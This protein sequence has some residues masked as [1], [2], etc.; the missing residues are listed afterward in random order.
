M[1]NKILIVVD[2]QY[3]F[4]SPEGALYVPG[5]E[6]IVDSIQEKINDTS[7]KDIIYTLDTHDNEEYISSEESKLF[8]IH[9]E[10]NS[11]GWDLFKIQ[12]RNRETKLILEEGIF[13]SA[14]D[15]SVKNEFVF[16]KDKFSIWE[17]NSNY[18]K[19][20]IE[21]Y[22]KDTEIVIVGVATNYCVFWN[23]MGYRERGYKNVKIMSD[24]VKGIYDDTYEKNIE[25]MKNKNI[26]FEG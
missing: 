5:A 16:M 11:F 23:A 22:D 10:F 14:K 9:C 7:F 12:T 20:F 18:E 3:D 6:T 8:P 15:F 21:R 26:K 17:G 24:S 2:Y 25:I 4:A 1:K 19:F 13:E